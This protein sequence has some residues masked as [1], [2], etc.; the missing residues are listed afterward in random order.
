[1]AGRTKFAA[2]SADPE[3]ML[4]FLGA[5]F[6]DY[7]AARTLLRS[8]LLVQGA[9]LASTSIEKYCKTILAFRGNEC[10]G[11]LKAAH[12]R[13][14][15]NFDAEVYAK[16]NEQFFGFLQK[17]YDLRYPDSLSLG[18][19]IVIRSRE[20]LAEL[21]RTVLQLHPRFNIVRRDGT[22]G[23]TKYDDML[24]VADG[25]LVED[26]HVLR[27]EDRQEFIAREN[28]LVYECR[29]ISAGPLMEAQYLMAPARSDG[30]FMREGF[31]EAGDGKNFSLS[32]EPTDRR[33]A[34]AICEKCGNTWKEGI[35][36]AGKTLIFDRP[37]VGRFRVQSVGRMSVRLLFDICER[38][39]PEQISKIRRE[40]ASRRAAP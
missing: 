27:A 39:E 12:W 8:G 21:D 11:H 4:H 24:Q 40:A 33:V 14:L 23:F 2:K 22:H 38:C 29:K 28:Q 6:D 3:K 19:N 20:V 25:R 35:K 36:V 10:P 7:L 15:R 37:P 26:N 17:A 32:A 13:C 31:R 34:S 1:V 16:L 30:L 5:A 18:Y 9:V